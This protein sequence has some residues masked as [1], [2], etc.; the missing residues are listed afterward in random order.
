MSD[1]SKI[2]W[3]EATWSP[4]I[5]CTRVSPGCDRCYA[6]TTA[7]IRVICGG[8]SGPGARLMQLDWAQSLRDQCI[9][10]GVPFHFKQFGEWAPT[11]IHSAGYVSDPKERQGES[12]PDEWYPELEWRR[13]YRRVGKKAAGRELDGREWNEFPEVAS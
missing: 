9:A 1:N 4:L 2:E 5:G 8:E 3:T 13:L 7:R 11:D 12:Y 10:A 6:I